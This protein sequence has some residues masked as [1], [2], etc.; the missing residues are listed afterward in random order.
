[1]SEEIAQRRV[2]DTVV[3]IEKRG[4]ALMLQYPREQHGPAQAAV[5]ILAPSP[6]NASILLNRPG[7]ASAFVARVCLEEL[8]DACCVWMSRGAPG[9][10]YHHTTT[11]PPFAGSPTHLVTIRLP[12][13]LATTTNEGFSSVATLLVFYVIAVINCCCTPEIPLPAIS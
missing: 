5:R 11:P 2:H 4:V 7:V 8:T 10:N 13:D 12:I 6:I 1:M 3:L 9:V